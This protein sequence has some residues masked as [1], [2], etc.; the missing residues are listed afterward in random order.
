MKKATIYSI[1]LAVIIILGYLGSFLILPPASWTGDPSAFHWTLANSVLYTLLHIG[2]A[3]LFLVGVGAY[4]ATLRT[5]YIQI[6]I[7]VILAGAG[8]AQVVI[9]NIFNL[10]QTP[11]VQDG[12]VM[13]PFVLAGVMIYLGTRAMAKLVN[14]RSIFTNIWVVSSLTALAVVLVSLVPHGS[15]SLPETFFDISN[16]ISVGDIVLYLVSLILV[17]QIKRHSGVYYT[18][19][20]A[21]LS[22]GLMGSVVITTS[23]LLG[24]LITGNVPAGYLLDVFVIIGGLVYLK[25]GQSFAKTKEL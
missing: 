1:V 15:S 4:K 18:E 14:V 8:L 13:I 12:G 3:V 10:I 16:A 25:A 21:W 11:W 9:L 5:A 23:I 2:A 24:T 20:M 19:S 17:L 22:L 6:A 7:G